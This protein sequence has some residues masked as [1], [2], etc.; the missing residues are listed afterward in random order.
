M[1]GSFGLA[2]LFVSMALDMTADSQLTLDGSISEVGDAGT[3]QRDQWIQLFVLALSVNLHISD[4]TRKARESLYLTQ[5]S[6][7]PR[8]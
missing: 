4:C 5:R 3:T 2:T 7:A 1:D 8:R 6:F